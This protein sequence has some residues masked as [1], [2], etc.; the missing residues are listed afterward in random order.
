M[1]RRAP[2]ILII[3]T[4]QQRADTI[5]ALGD[6]LIRTPHLDRLVHEGTAFR[7]AYTPCPVC[8][9]ARGS[10]STGVPPHQAGCSDNCGNA[11]V[12][13]PDFATLL[14][15]AGYQTWGYGKQYSRFGP[16]GQA[17]NSGG[18]DEFLDWNDYNAWWAGQGFD[19]L[20]GPRG[21]SNEYYY[22]PKPMGYPE[23][24]SRSH[25]IADHCVKAM[26]RRDPNR[27]FLLCAH[28]GEPHPPWNLPY[29]WNYLYRPVEMPP[30]IRP[31]NYRDYRCRAN[32][33]QNR[34]KWMEQAV[35]G[36]D[37]LLRII[38]AAYYGT[39]S[40]L[41]SQVGRILEAVGTAM[42]ET[43][44]IFTTDHGEMLGDY[45]CVGKRCMLEAAV[46]VPLIARLPGFLP[47]GRQCRAAA[48]LLDVMPTICEAAGVQTPPLDEAR[49]LREVAEMQPGERI[50]FSQFSRC[51]NGQYFAADGLGSYAY[52]A[53]D[54]RE[55]HFRLSDALAQGPI[56]PV[57]DHGRRLRAAVIERHR[58]DAY[59]QAVEGND[60]REHDVP[61]NPIH[62]DPDYGY[63][64]A[65][66]AERIQTDVNALGPGYARR[67]TDL[68]GGHLM[69]EHMVP[70]THEERQRWQEKV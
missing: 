17:G 59:S 38:R 21:H 13:L 15:D 50:V 34:Y 46:R 8:A 64:F 14:H 10:L 2:N 18:F 66:P 30:P 39:V 20:D 63:L 48:T 45:G 56:R 6:P 70:M 32:L 44:V 26:E 19:Y 9:P 35:E 29:P 53:A 16:K 42:D 4:D 60:W 54:R 36:D 37:T 62:S 68:G 58:H 41:D 11:P 7:R 47:G 24:F 1:V 25:W 69:A 49:S 52:S 40:Y 61:A 57:D 67:C 55:W 5:A 28:F 22:I 43:L 27:P 31:A 23:R 33:F 12:D 65:E 51:W 3:V